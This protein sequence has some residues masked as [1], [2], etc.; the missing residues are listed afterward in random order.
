MLMILLA[1]SCTILHTFV[2]CS[3][4][5]G[6]KSDP[7]LSDVMRPDRRLIIPMKWELETLD[8]KDMIRRLLLSTDG[9]HA[10]A[11]ARSWRQPLVSAVISELQFQSCHP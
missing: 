2:R 3:A 4:L 6:P 9:R 11:T 8:P 5:N 1:Q 7:N 10:E